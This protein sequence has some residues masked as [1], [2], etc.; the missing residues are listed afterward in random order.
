ML[1]A[2]FVLEDWNE[3]LAGI[4]CKAT[5]PC[6]AREILETVFRGI[7]NFIEQHE[8]IFSDKDAF[9]IYITVPI[10]YHVKLRDQ[11][12]GIIADSIPALE[13][14]EDGKTAKF[15]AESVLSWS[16]ADISFDNIYDIL[17]K[18]IIES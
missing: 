16:L 11:I 7:R 15:L 17:K 4:K 6:T 1:V 14:D 18:I 12:A 5:Y 9:A 10:S 13:N 2:A 8:K 3:C